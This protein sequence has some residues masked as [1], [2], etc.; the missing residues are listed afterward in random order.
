[1][2]GFSITEEDSITN[3]APIPTYPTFYEICKQCWTMYEPCKEYQYNNSAQSRKTRS[4]I[5]ENVL[6]D[7]NVGIRTISESEIFGDY[8]PTDDN[9]GIRMRSAYEFVNECLLPKGRYMGNGVN[10]EPSREPVAGCSAKYTSGRSDIV[11]YITHL[12]DENKADEMPE[13]VM[14]EECISDCE[15]INGTTDYISVNRVLCKSCC[16]PKYGTTDCNV[17]NRVS[18]KSCCE[19]IYGTTDCDV[20]LCKSRCEPINGTTDCNH[21]K[22]TMLTLGNHTSNDLH[23]TVHGVGNVSYPKY[24]S[25]MPDA[26][27]DVPNKMTEGKGPDQPEYWRNSTRSIGNNIG[28]C[29]S[30]AEILH[31]MKSKSDT[32]VLGN[33]AKRV[34]F[35]PNVH[36]NEFSVPLYLMS[37]K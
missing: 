21:M 4:M 26:V 7:V 5:K 24:P 28:T 33:T 3:D 35:N 16:E 14:R 2:R 36:I 1:M 17:M 11:E 23:S 8:N 13:S 25:G 20:V 12:N 6:S 22:D 29:M 30:S 32:K 10:A 27:I 18:C 15:P 37:T 19:P 9:M 31:R 34:Y